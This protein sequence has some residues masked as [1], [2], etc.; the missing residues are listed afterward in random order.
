MA[1]FDVLC[2]LPIVV[3]DTHVLSNGKQKSRNSLEGIVT[4]LYIL[5]CVSLMK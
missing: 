3:P 4:Y 5:V 2:V 1:V